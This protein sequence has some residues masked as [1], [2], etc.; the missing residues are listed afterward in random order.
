ME[1]GSYKHQPRPRDP[2]RP[3]EGPFLWVF[4]PYLDRNIF[5]YVY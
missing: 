5:V 1:K 2:F 4:I 3:E